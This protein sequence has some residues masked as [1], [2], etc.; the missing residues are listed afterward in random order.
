M[1]KVGLHNGNAPDSK[2][3]VRKDIGVQILCPPPLFLKIKNMKEFSKFLDDLC[4]E[5]EN[6]NPDW[7][8]C[9]TCGPVIPYLRTNKNS[10]TITPIKL[11][12]RFLLREMKG[13]SPKKYEIYNKRLRSLSL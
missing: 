6:L 12:A 7:E 1:R 11:R 8:Y 3:G 13:L 5:M 10:T 4:D 2:S 9:P